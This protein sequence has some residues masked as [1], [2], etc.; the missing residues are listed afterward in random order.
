MKT[1][2]RRWAFFISSLP[3]LTL[4]GACKGAEG[5]LLAVEGAWYQSLGF[6]TR[7]IGAY[8]RAREYPEVSAYAEFG[9]GAVYQALGEH[10]AALARYQSAEEGAL[11]AGHPELLYRV[12][13]NRGIA[14]FSGGDYEGAAAAF[15]GALEAES[16]R[17]DAKRNLELSLLRQDALLSAAR[18][19]GQARVDDEG[20]GASALF[21][22]LRTKE[23]EQWKNQD[24]D[25]GGGYT[26]PDY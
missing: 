12:R 9:L 10:R 18:A 13:Y 26:G 3:L 14:L 25:A 22:Y 2:F 8:L 19:A 23:E 5:K 11:R 20:D 7:A 4:A 6:P 1:F 21:N 24:W 16:S 15:R 17:I